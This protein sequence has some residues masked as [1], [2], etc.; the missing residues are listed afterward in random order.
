MV[1]ANK[2]EEMPE[3]HRIFNR[4]CSAARGYWD[5]IDCNH[6]VKHATGFVAAKNRAYR[7]RLRFDDNKQYLSLIIALPANDN[8]AANNTFLRFQNKH[9]QLLCFVTYDQED[10]IVK[11]IAKTYVPDARICKKAV[12]SIF[13]DTISLLEDD[14]FHNFLN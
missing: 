6:T 13:N 14:N 7:S 12:S 10:S 9:S 8:L 4:I 1:M 11:V 3:K 2:P 5:Q